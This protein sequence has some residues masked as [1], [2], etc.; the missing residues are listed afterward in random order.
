[1]LAS[2]GSLS[3]AEDDGKHI[4]GIKASRQGQVG[5]SSV[6]KGAEAQPEGAVTASSS[7]G[8]CCYVLEC[9]SEVNSQARIIILGNFIAT[10]L[11]LDY[12]YT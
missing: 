2:I 6:G 9:D 8:Y 4:L 12:M 11:N 5:S 7:T 3:Y 10:M 1:L